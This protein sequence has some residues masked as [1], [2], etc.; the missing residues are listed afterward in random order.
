MRTDCSIGLLCVLGGWGWWRW[1]T[2][3]LRH[4]P[5]VA[6]PARIPYPQVCPTPLPPIYPS[7]DT[8]LPRIHCTRYTLLPRKDTG[9]LKALYIELTLPSCNFWIHSILKTVLNIFNKMKQNFYC[10]FRATMSIYMTSN[11]I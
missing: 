3:T 1:Y 9:L 7:P 8:L 11:H 5:M 6:L 10:V 4:P 2:P